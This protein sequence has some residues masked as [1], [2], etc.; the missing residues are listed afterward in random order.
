M[1]GS[2]S[3]ALKRRHMTATQCSV[4][5]QFDDITS[6]PAAV[7][8]CKLHLQ[9]GQKRFQTHIVHAFDGVPTATRDLLS[10]P[11]NM[12]QHHQQGMRRCTKLLTLLQ[13]C[14]PPRTASTSSRCPPPVTHHHPPPTPLKPYTVRLFG[15][16]HDDDGFTML[17]QFDVDLAQF[18]GRLRGADVPL[19]VQ[20]RFA[21]SRVTSRLQGLVSVSATLTV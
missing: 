16:G 1:L 7:Y 6:L 4:R 13:L 8:Q 9:R 11:S 20:M 19:I 5:I 17:A 3:R 21:K 15:R 10:S 12:C 18:A 2:L 14:T